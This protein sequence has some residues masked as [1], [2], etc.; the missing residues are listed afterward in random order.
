MVLAVDIDSGRV[1]GVLMREGELKYW[2]EDGEGGF[3]ENNNFDGIN[4]DEKENEGRWKTRRGA[5]RLYTVLFFCFFK[6][7]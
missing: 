7:F 6:F 2:K 5:C 3:M 1:R 4:G